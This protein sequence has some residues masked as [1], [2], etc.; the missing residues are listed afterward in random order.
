MYNKTRQNEVIK[1]GVCMY[2]QTLLEWKE[3]V[4]IA[5]HCGPSHSDEVARGAGPSWSREQD[6]DGRGLQ[7]EV[8]HASD[9]AGRHTT[10]W[11]NGFWITRSRTM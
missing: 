5:I 10:S 9:C 2:V 8:R 3:A 4:G 1:S 11:T 6:G 7:V